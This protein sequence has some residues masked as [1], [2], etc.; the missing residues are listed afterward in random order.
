MASIRDAGIS[1]DFVHEP[2]SDQQTQIRLIQIDLPVLSDD[3][4]CEIECTI[5]AHPLSDPPPYVAISYT[6]G[7]NSTKRGIWVNK[8]RLNVG[9]NSWLAL[10]Q[11]RLHRLQQPL[12]IWMDVLSIDQA[13]DVEKIIQVGL[14][15]SIYKSAK[16]VLA[17]VGIHHHDSEYLAEQVNAH[18][19]Y[20]EHMRKLEYQKEDPPVERVYCWS[21]GQLLEVDAFECI[22]CGGHG[23]HPQFCFDCSSPHERDGHS[24]LES[25][26]RQHGNCRECNRALPFVWY[27]DVSERWEGR[28]CRACKR[29]HHN[30]RV[31]SDDDASNWILAD[32]WGPV[33]EPANQRTRISGSYNSRSRLWEM[34]RGSRERITKA[35]SAFSFRQYFTRLWACIPITVARLIGPALLTVRRLSRKPDLLI[36]SWSPAARQCP[37]STRF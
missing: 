1:G 34:Q 9:H 37:H 11:A 28:L 13:D 22:E 15:G 19:M 35:F 36:M 33:D 32:L 4:D 17:S 30:G 24:I 7:D 18:V 10:W 14:M 20:I 25:S 5:S 8:R 12:R 3:K 6:W 27:T 21:C 31:E 26:I 29:L 16:Y 23:K 2:L